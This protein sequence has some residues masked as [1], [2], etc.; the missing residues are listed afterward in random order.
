M[1]TTNLV[2]LKDIIVCFMFNISY[3]KRV[4]RRVGRRYG[5]VIVWDIQNCVHPISVKVGHVLYR[6]TLAMLLEVL[7]IKR[8]VG[9]CEIN[10][11]NNKNSIV[12]S[13]HDMP[14]RK[15]FT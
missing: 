9:N 8:S 1:G 3:N 13:C 7:F 5:G 4:C 2:L 10:F 11:Q 12:R 6:H 15:S 14:Y